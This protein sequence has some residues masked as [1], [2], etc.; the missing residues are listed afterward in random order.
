MLVATP[1]QMN[2]MDA[3]AIHEFGI[4]GMVLMENA[5]RRVAEETLLLLNGSTEKK[6]ILL[7]A[8]KGNNGGDAFA[9]ARHLFNMGF[10]VRVLLLAAR[11]QVQGDAASNLEIIRKMSIPVE[12]AISEV[13]LET[14]RECLQW[15]CCVIDG[16]LGTGLRGEV[17][18]W[19]GLVIEEINTAGRPVISI[20]VPSGVHGETGIVAGA[21]IRATKTI[22][23]ALPKTGLLLFPGRVF[24]GELIIAD[25]GLPRNI[26]ESMD[27]GTRTVDAAFAKEL[28]PG[29]R[30]DENK[31]SFGRAL[32]LTGSRGMMG[33]GCLAARAALRCGAGLVYVGVPD[34]L[35]DAYDIAVTEAITIPLPDE[36]NGR[37]GQAAVPVIREKL[38]HM[39]VLAVGP[40]LG[41][42][43]DTAAMLE[44]VLEHVQCPLVLD[45]DALNILAANPGL[46]KQCRTQVIVTPHP[47]EMGR[48]MGISSQEVQEDRLGTACRFAA[49]WK[50]VTVL[51]GAGTVIA[52][53]DGR[54]FINTTG[55][56]GLATAGTGDV[57]TGMIASLLAQKLPASE[58][59]LL[60]V[61][62]HG[63]A[64]D[65]AAACKGCNRFIAGDVVEEIPAAIGK[66]ISWS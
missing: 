19:L 60:G 33:A 57:L 28:V 24:C 21:A 66:L 59:A 48:L 44:A 2:R 23:F 64:G 65:L 12:E 63:L 34:S 15:A 5:A 39:N 16:I 56:P 37:L 43:S 45:A 13:H 29:R 47:G 40:G 32:L 53:P 25:I 50:A 31:G 41:T 36:G 62:L 35:A 6:N 42:H 20:D 54:S 58:A 11:E 22:T 17:K 18:G 46:W 3:A 26:W 10:D 38:D 61:Y 52:L 30:G 14:V 55:N 9:A 49:Q 7:V 1:T 8:G 27:I 4:P 51:K